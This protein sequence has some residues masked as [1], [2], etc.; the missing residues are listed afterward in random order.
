MEKRESERETPSEAKCVRGAGRRPRRERSGSSC[1][2][3]FVPSK[4]CRGEAN[5]ETEWRTQPE[6]RGGTRAE[7]PQKEPSSAGGQ[8]AIRREAKRGGGTGEPTAKK[9]GQTQWRGKDRGD[10]TGTDGLAGKRQDA[11]ENHRAG[12]AT[13]STTGKRRGRGQES[14]R[15]RMRDRGK[16]RDNSAGRGGHANLN[17]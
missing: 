12:S 16:G 9:T 10:E 14:E 17:V 7:D 2:V 15:R 1:I 3:N 13:G 5:G 8:G 11:R 6:M 4:V